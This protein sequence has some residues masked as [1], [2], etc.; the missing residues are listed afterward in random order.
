MTAPP[1]APIPS[2][3]EAA[4]YFVRLLFLVRPFWRPVLTGILLG[5]A[6]SLIGLATPLVTKLLVDEVYPTRDLRLLEVLVL[7][8]FS[9]ALARAFVG[10]VRSTYTQFA[11]AELNSTTLLFF[12]NHIQHQP[13]HFF[14]QRRVGEI[15]SRSGDVRASLAGIFRTFETI[16]TS[17]TYM[18]LVPPILVIMNWRLALLSLITLPITTLISIASGRI[19]RKLSKETAEAQAEMSATQ[20]EVLS[21]IRTLKLAS[22]EHAVYSQ[23]AAQAEDVLRLQVRSGGFGV[24]IGFVNSIIKAIGAAIYTWFA[25]TFITHGELTLGEFLAFSA[26]VGYMVGPVSRVGSLMAEFQQSAVSLGRMFEY[27]DAPPESPPSSVYAPR[28][29]IS[30]PIGGGFEL[31][32]VSF[33][34]SPDRPA[35]TS[36]SLRIP[37]RSVTALVGPSGAGKSSL[38]RL[39][40]RVDDPSSGEISIGGVPLRS[41][42]LVDLRRQMAVVWQEMGVVRG[43]MWDNLTIGAESVERSAVE[44]AVKICRLDETIAALPEGYETPIAEWG[45]SLS[46][47]Q[48][49][50]VALARALIR[51]SPVVLLDEA[52]ANIDVATESMILRDLFEATAGQTV[53]FVTH[54]I[55]T[56]ALADHVCLLVDGKVEGSGPHQELLVSSPRYADLYRMASGPP[57]DAHHLRSEASL[58]RGSTAASR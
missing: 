54:R 43:T 44:L 32:E 3:R 48:R 25:W 41:V 27:I 56:A 34:Y 20:M 1:V 18:V 11:S 12:F 46:A 35:L 29:V 52:T 28:P 57:D 24:F 51:K 49:Q 9:V 42:P 55:V 26:Y 2:L 58:L 21:Q 10:A 33:G 7:A 4:R 45:A 53:V 19:T 16:L 30:A 36:V 5:F 15:M 38:L 40:C 23:V 47:G 39:L 37:A 6:T 14:D 17:G 8:M 31:R 13:V 22:A 50:R